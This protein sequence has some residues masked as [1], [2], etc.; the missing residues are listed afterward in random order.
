ME[1]QQKPQR[2]QADLLHGTLW[3]KLLLLALPLAA[4]AILQQLFNAAD[5]AVVGRFVADEATAQAAMAAVG[6][7]GPIVNLLVSF[8]TGLSMGTNVTIAHNIGLQNHKAVRN[9]VHTAIV[10]AVL[11]GV[12]LGGAA[13]FFV[14][15][16]VRLMGVPAEVAAMSRLYLHIYLAGFPV[17][18]LYNVESAIFRS[19]GDTRTPLL[20]LTFSGLLNVAL[21]V[22]FVLVLGRTVDGVAVATVASN[23][24]SA[25]V[26]LRLLCRA[27][28]DIR[29][30]R[31]A[32]CLDPKALKR[33]LQIGFPAGVQGMVFSL[34][35]MCV[36]S[37]VNSLGTVVMAA[38]SAAYTLEAFTYTLLNS[39]SQACTTIVGQNC[40]AGKLDRCRRTLWVTLLCAALFFAVVAGFLLGFG[41]RLLAL[42]NQDPQ[43][44]AYGMVRLRNILLA[45]CFAL[46]VEVLS[47]YLRGFGMS[48]VPALCSLV[49]VCGIR[50][51]WV[52]LVFPHYHTFAGLMVSYP[53][54][55][56]T[57]AC[58]L[59]VACLAMRKRI[60][61]RV[62]HPESL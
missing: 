47:G 1:K 32:L 34:S 19:V 36:Q 55:L 53:I 13:Q 54:S 10:I 25:L 24:L 37:A 42:F 14:G 39:F 62:L 56:G 20:V 11:G 18:F 57:T 28:G 30:E 12:A 52:Y 29:V 15:A 41:E 31:R 5:V 58:I 2:A 4:T 26:L 21:N 8:F 44:I 38:S 43:V 59:I 45:H 60:E 16:I 33:I 23:A 61:A 6:S 35:N 46:F 50:V 3:D 22:F 27:Q 17:I 48:A 9:A 40:G 51:L 49:F 7:N